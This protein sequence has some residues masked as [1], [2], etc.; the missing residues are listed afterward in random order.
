MGHCCA[1]DQKGGKKTKHG[2]SQNPHNKKGKTVVVEETFA[3]NGDGGEVT[4]DGNRQ[5]EQ[6]VEGRV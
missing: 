2:P 5:D 6:K 4:Y 1:T 3:S